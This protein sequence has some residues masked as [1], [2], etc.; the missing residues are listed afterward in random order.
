VIVAA[1]ITFQTADGETTHAPLVFMAVGGATPARSILDSGSDVHLLN[2]DLADELGLDKSPGEEGTDHSGNTMPSWTVG[3]VSAVIDGYAVTLRESF[4]IPAPPPFPRMGIRA[5]LSPHHLHPTAFVVI[6]TALH[7]LLFVEG[8]DDDIQDF[9]QSRQP[10]L[11]TLRLVRDPGHQA[12]VV[13]AAIDGFDEIPALLDTG[14]KKTEFSAAAMG[15]LTSETSERL[16]GGVS[17]LDYAGWSVG[18]RTLVVGGQRLSV[19]DLKV[20]A[21]MHD[22]Q[23]IIGMD[24]MAGTVLAAA[25]DL[26]RPVFW[27]VPV[28]LAE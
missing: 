2:E 4:S 25:A 3:D 22:P 13:K 20:R 14:G 1:P 24:V 28:S 16:G 6:D 8:K 7:E 18:P 5:M 19:P 27:Q 17:G 21:E 23:A 10:A 15:G 26:A 12:V 11:A 9:L